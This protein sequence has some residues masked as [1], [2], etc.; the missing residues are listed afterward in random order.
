MNS[1]AS[2]QLSDLELEFTREQKGPGS[3]SPYLATGKVDSYVG[4]DI[5]PEDIEVIFFEG[6]GV[7]R[8]DSI[9]A[10]SVAQQEAVYMERYNDVMAKFP[11]LGRSNDT[12][13]NSAYSADEVAPLLEECDRILG[14]STDPRVS[15]AV[16]KF[17]I[18]G[19]KAAGESVGLDLRPRQ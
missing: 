5:H 14:G 10:D 19:K 16:Q 18:A 1:E 9:T 2:G 8:W 15:R 12:F 3:L 17:V 6:I 11:L 4:Y 13:Q 7:P